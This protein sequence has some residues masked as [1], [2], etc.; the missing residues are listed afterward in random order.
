[1]T[2]R[3]GR[4]Y[5]RRVGGVVEYDKRWVEWFGEIRAALPGELLVEH[6]GSTAVPGLAAKPIV[7]VDVV[8]GSELDVA[9]AIAAITDRG[10]S[11]RGNLGILHREAFTGRSDLPPHHLYV[12][13]AGSRPHLDHID[14]RDYLRAHPIDAARYGD[15]KRALA[16]LLAEDREAYLAGKSELVAELLAT[17]R[18]A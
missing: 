8:V 6:V 1:M 3:T 17:A 10:W 7:D 16:P 13:V 11:H 15:L 2:R 12:V 14:L 18:L 5:G 9:A 4:V